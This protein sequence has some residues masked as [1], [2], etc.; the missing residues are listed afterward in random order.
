M[1]TNSLDPVVFL[2]VRLRRHPRHPRHRRAPAF[3]SEVCPVLG[4]FL[5][6]RAPYLQSP[7]QGSSCLRL[8]FCG[9]RRAFPFYGFKERTSTVKNNENDPRWGQEN[10]A[11]LWSARREQKYR[12]LN[13][14]LRHWPEKSLTF[15]VLTPLP[16]SP[17]QCWIVPGRK[18][19]V[20]K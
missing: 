1:W 7:T 10:G 2:S 15:P 20:S 6:V 14:F 16:A 19:E 17:C 12:S 18:I 4:P 3:G 5:P 8:R 9:S 13:R 11:Y